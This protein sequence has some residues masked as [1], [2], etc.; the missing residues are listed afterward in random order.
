MLPN[1]MTSVFRPTNT[2]AARAQP[3]RQRDAG[4]RVSIYCAVRNMQPME[5][6]SGGDVDGLPMLTKELDDD[7]V[8]I[9][10]EGR[11]GKTEIECTAVCY[12]KSAR[13][14]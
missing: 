8:D 12:A 11:L 13:R 9:S 1:S 3:S 5:N 6:N 2:A 7:A 10:V 4:K 14:P